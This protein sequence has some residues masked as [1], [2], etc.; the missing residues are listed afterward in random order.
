[1]RISFCG[2]LLVAV[3]VLP[4]TLSAAYATSEPMSEKSTIRRSGSWLIEETENFSICRPVGYRLNADIAEKFE[5]L[6]QNLCGT[7]SPGSETEKWNPRCHIVIHAGLDS[8]MKEVGPGGRQ[9][10]GSSLLDFD[11]G[12][13]TMRRVDIRGDQADWMTAA[14]AHELT[15]IVLADRFAHV[16]IPHW[17]DE[18]MAILA[19][20][21]S[22]RRLHGKDLQDALSANRHFRLAELLT[23]EEYPHP[24]RMGAF[25]GQS[26]S[27][28]EFLTQLGTRDEL[29]KFVDRATSQ[30]YDVALREVYEINSVGEL[31]KRWLQGLR[32]G[33]SAEISRDETTSRARANALAT[34]E[35]N[36]AGAAVILTA[37][38]LD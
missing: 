9:T 24:S 3:S 30:G 22:K 5:E 17:A 25:Y 12:R 14:L 8:Y 36:R 15:H 33:N 6:R 34:S 37:A 28:V 13:V 10:T 1:M 31:E 21:S 38:E 18:G 16:Q 7:W 19:D 4:G 26:A 32:S 27:L 11:K 23:L 20:P 29:V 2:L 35:P